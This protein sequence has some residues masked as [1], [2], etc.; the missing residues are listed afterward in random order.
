LE[1]FEFSVENNLT[2]SRLDSGLIA[3]GLPLSR[4]KLRQVIDLGGVFINKRRIKVASK[5]ISVGDRLV[6]RYDE[7]ALQL[8]KK[9]RQAMC[10]KDI[11]F[12]NSK[13]IVVNKPAGLP[14]QPTRSQAVDHLVTWV[15]NGLKEI[16]EDRSPILVHRLDKET[17]GC[18][19][20]CFNRG[21]LAFLTDQF[22]QRSVA[23]VY[24]SLNYGKVNSETWTINNYLK[25]PDKYGNVRVTSK[26]DGRL[27]TT[28][29][30]LKESLGSGISL[31]ESRPITGRT[32]QIRVHSHCSGIPI[33]G[34]KKY[35]D[36]SVCAQSVS[37]PHHML[38]ARS[39]TFVVAPG[40]KKKSFKAPYSP[41]FRS[42]MEGL[43]SN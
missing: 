10:A 14:S 31:I 35:A 30:V 24:H 40:E 17:S 5:L 39:L 26:V 19:V 28:G 4:R 12:M 9:P 41:V 32:H 43:R 42:T 25:K 34:D 23:K 7:N 36:V 2:G 37:A 1:T 13:V 21:T 27:A 16:G 15:K 20:L 33:L 38:H 11:L 29:F 6:V 22:R 3:L 18:V 8:L